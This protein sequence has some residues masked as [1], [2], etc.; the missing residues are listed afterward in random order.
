MAGL[1]GREDGGHGFGVAHFTDEDDVRILAEDAAEGVDEIGSVAANFD[2]LH[3]GL[4]VGVM[5]F[6]GVFNGHDVIAAAVVDVVD[7]RGECGGLAAAGGAGDEDEALATVGQ[8]GEDGREMEQLESGNARGQKA[9][10][11]REG[12]ALVM[13]VGTT[14]DAIRTYESEIEGSLVLEFAVL[15]CIE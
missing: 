1:G 11:G 13:D 2:L 15:V 7:E 8:F 9:D 10:A 4:Q 5:V 6:D 12:A 3:D 14:T